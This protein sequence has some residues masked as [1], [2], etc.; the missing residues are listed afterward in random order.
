MSLSKIL[1]TIIYSLYKIVKNNPDDNISIDI[2]EKEIINN[3]Y[4]IEKKNRDKKKRK[5]K[6]KNDKCK[7]KKKHKHGHRSHKHDH[8]S[9]KHRHRHRKHRCK[10]VYQIENYYACNCKKSTKCD[11]SN[12]CCD[13]KSSIFTESTHLICIK[14][15]K[16]CTVKCVLVGGG[17][18][19][20]IGFCFQ[21]YCIYGGGGSSGDSRSAIL[22][23]EENEVWKIMIGAG[24]N[25]KLET[26]GQKTIITGSHNGTEKFILSAHGG[27]N[28]GPHLPD[29]IALLG[30]DTEQAALISHSDLNNLVKG[31]KLPLPVS[32]YT[33]E[34]TSGH[35]GGVGLPSIPA[36][37]G[38]GGCSPITSTGGHCGTTCKP[39]GGCGL[40]G[41]GGGGSSCACYNSTCHILSGCGGDGY[42]T[43]TPI[44]K[45]DKSCLYDIIHC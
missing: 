9:H 13:E 5:H 31:G 38:C 37:C 39:C 8:K 2:N 36:H 12:E 43:I 30:L 7:D 32:G 14:F 41:S 26:N 42:V 28:G 21:Y 20:G 10:K 29:V 11:E 23:V 15:K 4:K 1:S 16:A 34:S 33:G 3:I 24:G 17:G 45:T 22:N 18:A 6:H 27:M 44:C 40:Y 19:G 35:D 25:A